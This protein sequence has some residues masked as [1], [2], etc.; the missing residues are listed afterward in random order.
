[1]FGTVR[2][3]FKWT[4]KT[5]NGNSLVGLNVIVIGGTNGLG[6]GISRE[7]ASKGA[8][9]TV[10][11]RTFRDQSIKN[12]TFIKADL[13]TIQASIQVT[14]IFI[15]ISTYLDNLPE[16]NTIGCQEPSS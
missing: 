14:L 2:K 13:T 16:N 7:L 6:Q 3:D 9:V 12:L 5:L 10:V 11:G 1:M 4:K 8:N 15:F